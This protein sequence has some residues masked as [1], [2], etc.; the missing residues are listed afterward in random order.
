MTYS[1]TVHIE[2]HDRDAPFRS[3]SVHTMCRYV[4][5]FRS[6][7]AV[8]SIVYV[9]RFTHTYVETR[10]S[11]TVSVN[12]ICLATDN[13]GVTQGRNKSVLVY[14]SWRA[15]A[16][17]SLLNYDVLYNKIHHSRREPLLVRCNTSCIVVGGGW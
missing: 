3:M 2:E 14:I 6:P 17:F 16:T 8:Q 7:P 11:P 4:V 9:S 10:G 5:P 1:S 12:A 15:S 13:G